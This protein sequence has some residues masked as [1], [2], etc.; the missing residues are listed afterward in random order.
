MLINENI[1]TH[2]SFPE[3]KWHLVPFRTICQQGATAIKQE[4]PYNVREHESFNASNNWISP[5]KS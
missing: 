4:L 5:S 3:C 1:Q 2:T